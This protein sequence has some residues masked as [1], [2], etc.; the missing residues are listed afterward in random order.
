MDQA[1]L[2]CTRHLSNKK[3][4]TFSYITEGSCLRACFLCNVIDRGENI[5]LDIQLGFVNLNYLNCHFGRPGSY[6][7][8]TFRASVKALYL[9]YLV[10]S[11]DNLAHKMLHTFE[12]MDPINPTFE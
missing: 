10:D 2:M 6:S 12:K 8:S 7:I 5:L 4:L 3:N 1:V 11:K 9:E